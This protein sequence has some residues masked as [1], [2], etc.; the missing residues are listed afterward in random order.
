MLKSGQLLRRRVLRFVL[1]IAIISSIAMFA[2]NSA[3]LADTKYDKGADKA[4]TAADRVVE[5]D[6]VKERFGKSE[7]GDQLLDNARSK[8]NK[9]LKS[10]AEEAKSEDDESLPHS[11]R[12]FLRNLEENN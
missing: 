10:L 11:K 3:A 1:L 8:A 6:A 9:K 4:E 12:L 7:S 2:F 5:Q